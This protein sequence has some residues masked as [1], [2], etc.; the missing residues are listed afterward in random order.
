MHALASV[1][2]GWSIPEHE[3]HAAVT[4]ID[5][6]WGHQSWNGAF[7]GR[8]KDIADGRTPAHNGRE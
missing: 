5:N 4:E 6:D 1:M 2:I 3:T 7:G 8:N